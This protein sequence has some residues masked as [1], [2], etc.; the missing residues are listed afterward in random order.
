MHRSKRA[1]LQNSNVCVHITQLFYNTAQVVF[2]QE[3]SVPGPGSL[4]TAESLAPSWPLEISQDPH[5]PQETLLHRPTA[6]IST[7]V[8]MELRRTWQHVNSPTLAVIPVS[9][10]YVPYITHMLACGHQYKHTQNCVPL[11]CS[12]LLACRLETVA[13]STGQQV[14]PLR[15]TARCSILLF[16]VFVQTRQENRE[17]IRPIS[18]H[19]PNVATQEA[20]QYT[21]SRG[22]TTQSRSKLRKKSFSVQPSIVL[23]STQLGKVSYDTGIT[24]EKIGADWNRSTPW[25]S[26]LSK[27]D[28]R[29]RGLPDQML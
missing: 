15:K 2:R 19:A 10:G 18:K 13:G 20:Q 5:C 17:S 26:I 7:S 29:S 24:M 3:E 12:V 11:G 1:W 27:L 14:E 6:P 21:L 23:N 4:Q 25:Q 9:V 8:D 22:S 16:P 28:E